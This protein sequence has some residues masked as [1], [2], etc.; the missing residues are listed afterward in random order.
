MLDELHIWIPRQK[1]FNGR[2]DYTLHEWT[3]WIDMHYLT[4]TSIKGIWPLRYNLL[5][6]ILFVR[7]LGWDLMAEIS[8][9]PT[10]KFSGSRALMV[11]LW[12]S[13]MVSADG[14]KKRD[15]LGSIVQDLM[16]FYLSV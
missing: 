15:V 10:V 8:W 9:R 13:Q 6:I 12:V 3:A 7:C 4:L 14:L 5:L 2:G 16:V 11:L 1:A